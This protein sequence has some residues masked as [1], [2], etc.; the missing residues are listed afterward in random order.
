MFYNLNSYI[1]GELSRE[2]PEWI[3][4]QKGLLPL[5][6]GFLRNPSF[7]KESQLIVIQCDQSD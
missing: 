7:Q 1:L 5:D 6:T 3:Q 2:Q 4:E